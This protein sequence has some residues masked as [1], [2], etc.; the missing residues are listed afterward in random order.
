M[1]ALLIVG[2]TGVACLLGALVTDITLGSG[3][4]ISRQRLVLR[5][6]LLAAGLFFGVGG[7]VLAAVVAF[8]HTYATQ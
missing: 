2:L 5:D 4:G 1:T 3:P 7:F 8:I 6:G